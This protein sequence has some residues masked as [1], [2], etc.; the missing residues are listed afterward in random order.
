ML[1]SVAAALLSGCIAPGL[2]DIV[3]KSPIDPAGF[4][5]AASVLEDSLDGLEIAKSTLVAKISDVSV[6][7]S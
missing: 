6:A 4:A 1:P 5:F 7:D 3:A 2:P